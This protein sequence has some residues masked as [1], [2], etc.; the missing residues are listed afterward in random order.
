MDQVDAFTP[1]PVT[2][3][4]IFCSNS[5]CNRSPPPAH[6][7]ALERLGVEWPEVQRGGKLSDTGTNAPTSIGRV[8][9]LGLHVA[10]LDPM[11][12]VRLVSVLHEHCKLYC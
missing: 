1:P 6:S 9:Q 8:P 5:T 2:F 10:M 7:R 11:Q 12:V 4:C 3:E